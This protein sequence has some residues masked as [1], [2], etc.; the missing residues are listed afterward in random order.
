MYQIFRQTGSRRKLEIRF[1]NSVLERFEVPEENLIFPV[2][3][4]MFL[5]DSSVDFEEFSFKDQ[6]SFRRLF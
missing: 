5:F 4:Q 1:M 2:I 3:A 6:L